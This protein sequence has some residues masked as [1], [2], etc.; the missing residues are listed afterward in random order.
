MTS[1]LVPTKHRV[2]MYRS[3]SW[4]RIQGTC[5]EVLGVQIAAGDAVEPLPVQEGRKVGANR[6]RPDVQ[7]YQ[8]RARPRHRRAESRTAWIRGGKL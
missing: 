7:R 6:S 3:G 1:S 5:Q 2:R 8:E 4:R